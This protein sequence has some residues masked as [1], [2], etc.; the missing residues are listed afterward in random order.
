MDKKSQE[1]ENKK[2]NNDDK[3]RC[4]AE[5]V[6]DESEHGVNLSLTP[7]W[8]LVVVR[9]VL[10]IIP[11][12]GYIHPDEYFQ[13]L[14]IVTGDLFGVESSRPWEFNVTSPIR[15]VALPYLYVGLPLLALKNAA[16]F[17]HLWFGWDIKTPYMMLV[18]PRLFCCLI[19]FLTDYCLYKICYIY[20]QNYRAR[21]LTLASSYVMLV[22]GTHTFSNT[23]EM[24]LASVLIYLVA[25]C[26]YQSDKIIYQDEYL[27]DCYSS[28][29]TIRD[30]VMFSRLRKSLPGHSLSSCVAIATITVLGVFNRPTFLAYAFPPVFFWLHRGLGSKYIGL[31][32]FHLRIVLLAISALPATI[33]LILA[34]SWY[35]GYLTWDE[36]LQGQIRIDKNFVVTPYNFIQY[37]AHTSNLANH[38]LHPRITHLLINIPVLFNVLGIAALIAL[39]SIIL[40]VLRRRLSELPRIQSIIGLMV[41]SFIVPVGLLSIFPHQ[42]PRFLIPVT[43]PIVFLNSQRICSHEEE[44]IS[45]K[46]EKGFKVFMKKERTV[47]KNSILTL[48]YLINIILTAVYGFIH[49]AGVY[50]LIQHFSQELAEKPRLTQVHLVTSYI[51]PLPVSLLQIKK[52]T[53]QVSSTG[54]RYN[55][56]KD[57]FTYEIG[58]S[59]SVDHAAQKVKEIL[60]SCEQ[61]WKEKRMKYRL[62]LAIP[63]S[64]TEEFQ[65]AAFKVNMTNTVEHVFYPH[66]ST[67]AMPNFSMDVFKKCNQDHEV[68]EFGGECRAQLSLAQDLSFD[69]AL[70][71]FSH[72]VHQF[73]LTL[74]RIRI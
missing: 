6:R 33:L 27:R 52:R 30:K 68:D 21:L 4:S 47:K 63:S 15:N 29:E 14:E 20:G 69:L 22:Y 46:Q 57:F 2:N 3:N 42:E 58:L 73:G 48:W 34:D 28:A 56:A 19:S 32:E 45:L 61:K 17:I 65:M 18:V 26:M 23:V 60:D 1:P 37:N 54:L 41:T 74:I 70:R 5:T 40:R 25:D 43:L 9:I 35:F 31:S 13:S 62:Y 38:G 7:Y 16:P 24:A 11:Q 55:M 10:T 71:Y 8:L 64:K 59:E 53:V 72:I 44:Y 67:E 36:I 51:Y 49:Q 12:S 50:P 66:L 39:C